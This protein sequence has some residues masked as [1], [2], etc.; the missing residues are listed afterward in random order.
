MYEP[1]NQLTDCE[2]HASEL[3]TPPFD[4]WQILLMIAEY[5]IGKSVRWAVLLGRYLA[6]G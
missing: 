4:T 5:A 6:K 1:T 3:E 2:Q